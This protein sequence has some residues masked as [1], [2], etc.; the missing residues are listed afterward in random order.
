MSSDQC[1]SVTIGIPVHNGEK[2]ITATLN[3][4]LSQTYNNYKIIICDNASTDNTPQICREYVRHDPRFL[5]IRND[6]NI[7]A[8]RNFNKCFEHSCSEFFVWLSADD[9]YA[10][11]YLERCVDLLTRR[12]DLAMVYTDCEIIDENGSVIEWVSKYYSMADSSRI[13]LRLVSVFFQ[14]PRAV[15]VFGVFRRNCL[16]H[17]GLTRNIFNGDRLLLA[18]AALTGKFGRVP[19][20]LFCNRSH[21]GRFSENWGRLSGS[22]WVDQNQASRS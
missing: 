7:G 17:T 20:F 13:I 16:E 2:F 22:E 1:A 14:D 8:P 9:V 12:A 5:Y 10:P 11:T 6:I 18:E 21:S 3:S 15:S 4:V 19:E